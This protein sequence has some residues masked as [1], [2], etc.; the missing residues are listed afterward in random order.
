MP[1]SMTT[2]PEK[3]DLAV[4]V[5]DIGRVVSPLR[6][7]GQARFDAAVVDV[8]AEAQ[9]LEN[10]TKVQIVEIY[11]NRVVVREVVSE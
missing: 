10:E 2:T 8:V 11:G 6:P 1:I 3:A 4:K 7:A 5:G 9:F